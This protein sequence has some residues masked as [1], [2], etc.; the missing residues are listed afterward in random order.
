MELNLPGGE[1][2]GKNNIPHWIRRQGGFLVW[3]CRVPAQKS[4]FANYSGAICCVEG[5]DF[6]K[7]LMEID[8]GFGKVPIA[9]SSLLVKD[10]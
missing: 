4:S 6:W 1:I 3:G 7:I 2:F 9:G 8:G 10:G 5:A